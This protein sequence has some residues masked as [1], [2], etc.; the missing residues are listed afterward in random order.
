MNSDEVEVQ[1]QLTQGGFIVT[2][3]AQVFRVMLLEHVNGSA[4]LVVFHGPLPPK[5]QE[6]WVA[7]VSRPQPRE[8]SPGVICFASGTSITTPR[9]P[10]QV[11]DLRPGD[12]VQTRDNGPQQVLWTGQRRFSTTRLRSFPGLAPV[13]IRAAA[14]GT[15]VPDRDLLV[16]P[17][18][19][20]LVRS[21]QAQSIYGQSEVLVAAQD[22]IDDSRIFRETPR[23]D[24]T[25]VHILLNRHEVIVANGVECESFHPDDAD[26]AMLDQS[27]RERLEQTLGQAPYGGHA[28]RVLTRPEAAILLH[29]A[30]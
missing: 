12:W 18:H 19:R 5:A 24:I 21:P 28:R 30:A 15:G 20:I 9:G 17:R 8:T 26:P 23:C 6:L 7:E 25:Y 27:D 11:Q 4:P 3:G 2:N 13:R 22:L 10:R 14:F 1:R 16:S 29:R